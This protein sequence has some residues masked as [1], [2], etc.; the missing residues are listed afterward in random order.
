MKYRMNKRHR[1]G[2]RGRI[3]VIFREGCRAGDGRLLVIGRAN[4]REDGLVRGAVLVTKK[5]G[6]A[7]RRNR[8]KRLT[9]EAFRL[10]RETL[11]AGLDFL[12]LPRAGV[13][14]T[15]AD[16]RKSLLSLVRRIAKTSG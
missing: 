5:H 2:G 7:V 11:P 1:I 10:E 15:L 6:N 13:N 4:R 9:R 14:H 3:G 8:V 12:L 16:L